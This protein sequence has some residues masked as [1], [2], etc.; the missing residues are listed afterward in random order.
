M[1]NRNIRGIN[2]EYKK[3]NNGNNH[4]NNNNNN[5]FLLC[6]CTPRNKINYED[7]NI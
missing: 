3:Y 6:F 7:Y 4:N 5:P 1:R 2:R